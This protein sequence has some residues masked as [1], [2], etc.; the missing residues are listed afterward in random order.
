MITHPKYILD[1][2]EIDQVSESLDKTITQYGKIKL[3]QKLKLFSPDT[4]NLIKL[5]KK[6]YKDYEYRINM[7]EYLTK[8]HEIKNTGKLWFN[9]KPND[10]LYFGSNIFNNKYLLN[11]GNKLKFTNAFVIILIYLCIYIFFYAYGVKISVMDC[12]NGIF[13]GYQKFCAFM[14]SMLISN[15]IIVDY[16]SLSMAYSYI[17]YQGYSIYDRINTAVNHYRKCNQFN[18]TYNQMVTFVNISEKIYADDKFMR[19]KKIEKAI[20]EL[21]KY[22]FEGAHLGH[23]LFVKKEQYRY[24]KYFDIVCNYIGNIDLRI[25]ICNLLDTHNYNI[26]TVS[27][28][29]IP[30]IECTNMWNPLLGYENSVTNSINIKNNNIIVL[31]GPNKSGKTTLMKTLMLNIL[32]AQ[33]LGIAPCSKLK[34]TPFDELYTSISIPGSFGRDSDRLLK[35]V[36]RLEKNKKIF[37]IIDD[38]FTGTSHLNGMALSKALIDNINHNAKKSIT[39]ISTHFTSMLSDLDTGVTYYKFIANNTQDGYIFPYTISSGIS[40]QSISI[41]LLK[42]KGYNDHILKSALTYINKKTE[43][44]HN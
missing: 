19:T 32:I 13:Q 43:S 37:G 26:P 34:F 23:N 18:K 20:L 36:N 8:I 28:S 9:E 33:S 27:K 14:L 3:H 21:K 16:I 38:L 12:A 5:N 29:S 35:Y 11:M 4:K 31:T 2:L 40:D 15:K 1:D 41:Q 44:S 30:K 25:S 42:E 22:F 17:A 6:I 24:V 39:I 10:D 7:K